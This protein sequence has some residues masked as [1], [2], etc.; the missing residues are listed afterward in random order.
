MKVTL[1]YEVRW[2]N[3][4]FVLIG[5]IAFLFACALSPRTA[6]YKMKKELR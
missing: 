4:L 6:D 2:Y 3:E 5:R 1:S